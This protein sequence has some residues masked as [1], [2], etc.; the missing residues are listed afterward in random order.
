ML[1]TPSQGLPYPASRREM[2]NAPLASELLARAVD[3]KLSALST[4]WT[5]EM[6]GPTVVLNLSANQTGIVANS[7][8][9]VFADTITKQVP[10]GW[11][12]SSQTFAARDDGWY[13]LFAGVQLTCESTISSGTKREMRVEIQG[14]N[15]PLNPSLVTEKYIRRDYERN[16]TTDLSVEFVTFLRKDYS[17]TVWVNH[18]NAATLRVDATNTQFS[19]TKICA[20]V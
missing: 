17:I 14:S 15:D 16:G 18:A 1:Y 8:W 19:W 11:S 13:H 12:T 9:P 4:G 10:A 6:N 3:A 2:A 20:E 7:D 5:A